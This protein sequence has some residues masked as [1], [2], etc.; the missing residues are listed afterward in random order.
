MNIFRATAFVAVLS[1]L[2]AIASA[3]GAYGAISDPEVINVLSTM[4]GTL[5]SLCNGGNPAACQNL[6]Y[7][8]NLGSSMSNA[9]ADCQ[10]GN[11]NGCA[12]YQQAYYQLGADY[13]QFANEMA[14]MQGAGGYASAP[15]QSAQ[16]HMDNMQ[17]I[18]NWGQ[19]ALQAGRE[20]SAALDRS[21]EI[22]MNT[23]RN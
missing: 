14:M 17:A 19:A 22:Y 3:Q 16:Q 9:A 12:Y 10:R 21:H 1:S 23:L 8:Q 15:P 5:S 11:Q 7:V 4:S 20:S 13:Q 18:H 2:P 6:G